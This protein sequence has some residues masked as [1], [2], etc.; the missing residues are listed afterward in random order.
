[1]EY[2]QGGVMLK[3]IQ[4]NSKE[5]FTINIKNLDGENKIKC[6]VCE[7]NG[8]N[9]IL[10][11]NNK[12]SA[13]HC[14]SCG[15]VYFDK[16]SNNKHITKAKAIAVPTRYNKDTLTDYFD[17]RGID[18]DVAVQM[19]VT[20]G[21]V[22][23][24]EE[25]DCYHI[26]YNYYV[27][28]EVL[29]QKQKHP[30]NKAAIRSKG[31][32]DFLYNHNSFV[33][34]VYIGDKTVICV[35]GEE[36]CLSY[37]AAGFKYVV[38]V[39]SG[40]ASFNFLPKYKEL[41]EK[42]NKIYLSFDNDM[43]GYLCKEEFKRLFNFGNMYEVEL[44]IHKD[45]NDALLAEG[46]E[47]LQQCVN[48]A[49]LIPADGWITFQGC[50]KDIDHI[51]SHGE[52]RGTTTYF[53]ELDRY[54]SW[55]NR[56][57]TLLVSHPAR[58]KTAFVNN[59]TVLKSLNEPSFRWG[60]YSPEEGDERDFVC[61]LL[62]TCTGRVLADIP[63]TV[64]TQA[65]EWIDKHFYYLKSPNPCITVRELMALY[66]QGIK[67]YGL[68]A[69]VLDPFTAITGDQN[70]RHRDLF[71]SNFL[72]E[73]RALINKYN[74][75]FLV[76][77][78]ATIDATE[79]GKIN[80]NTIAG[81]SAWYR[82]VDNLLVLHRPNFKEDRTDPITELSSVKIKKQ[83]LVGRPGTAVLDYDFNRNRYKQ[84]DGFCPYQDRKQRMARLIQERSGR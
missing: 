2:V 22:N 46:I 74:I 81:G 79:N 33:E 13:G 83:R 64:Y 16:M 15:T 73:A 77:T 30:V 17:K 65:Y 67:Q 80:G 55:R 28:N 21:K 71:V 54:W 3:K 34:S 29:F 26:L 9:K 18:P 37:I 27:G 23:T 75:I 7:R 42:C 82:G 47:Y 40:G 12:I 24:K 4:N 5:E 56:E 39:P 61:N 35:E 11:Y 84:A 59:I 72:V 45:A 50:K 20:T 52:E 6:P 66:E 1:M 62:H 51:R 57:V 53:P 70:I 10:Y 69:V 43:V 14:F 78:H 38:S 60:F 36:D 49:V 76:V 44:G 58:G 19:G 48:E 25:G 68:N 41:F 32:G 8:K 31:S 63:D